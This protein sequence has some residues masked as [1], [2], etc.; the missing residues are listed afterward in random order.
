MAKD[1]DIND[2]FLIYALLEELAHR[3]F[4]NVYGFSYQRPQLLEHKDAAV[5]YYTLHTEQLKQFMQSRY[6]L[7]RN[8][9]SDG[10]DTVPLPFDDI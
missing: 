4:R 10:A 7:R 2:D 1:A 3:T 8:L 5:P 9:I 6:L